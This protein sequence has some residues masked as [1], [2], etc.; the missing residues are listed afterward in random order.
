MF[1]NLINTPKIYSGKNCVLDNAN[2]FAT[3]GERCLIVTS[4]TAGEKSGALADVVKALELNNIG[5]EVFNK[6]TENPLVST[7]IEGGAV[8]REIGADFIIGIGGGSPLDASK[9]IAICA[10]NPEY[11]I[12]GLYNRKNPSKALPV[13]LIGTTSGTGSEVTGVSVL[14]NDNTMRKKSIGGAD[15]YGAVAFCDAKYTCSM[16]Y[17][18]TVTTA[19][20]AFAHAVEGF[21][22][23]KCTEYAFMYSKLALPLLYKGLKALNESKS[24]PDEKLREELYLGSIYAGLELNVC[25]AAFPHTVG[26]VLTEEF[27]IPHGKACT[28][29]MPLLLQNAKETAEERFNL[30]LKCVDA[31]ETDLIKIIKELTNVKIEATDE[32]I[33]KW[34][35]RWKDGN[36]NFDNSPGGF[37]YKRA[38]EAIKALR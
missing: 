21:F 7:V 25:G 27:G 32:Q 23:P 14:T 26:Y 12:N 33:E 17:D 5:Y 18:V 20:D 4:R 38:E 24:I 3:Y 2:I 13:V 6:I 8:A 30:F 15:C 35:S 1:P 29:F 34:C 37:D 31:N 16:S 36:K 28:A 10:K 19:L 22:S 9:A 11:D